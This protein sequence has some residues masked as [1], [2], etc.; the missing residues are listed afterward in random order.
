MAG[1]RKYTRIPPE[2]TG[3]RL[4][5]KSHT[6]IFYDQK[7]K[8]IALDA[9]LTLI[10]SGLVG[11]VVYVREDTTDTGMIAV[12]WNNSSEDSDTIVPVVGEKIQLDNGVVAEVASVAATEPYDT[13]A[14]VSTT[15]SYDNHYQGQMVSAQGEAY[16]R[17]GEGPARVNAAGKLEIDPSTIIAEYPFVYTRLAN[18][19]SAIATGAGTATHDDTTGALVLSTTTSAADKITYRSNLWHHYTPGVPVIS[20]LTVDFG[21]TGKANHIRRWGMFDDNDG[22]FFEL[23]ATTFG[24]V[25]RTSTSG[26]VQETNIPRS[27]WNRDRLDGSGSRATNPSGIDIDFSKLNVFWM[28]YTWHGAGIVRFGIFAKGQRIVCHVESFANNNA[29][30]YMRRASLPI[31]WELENTG[32]TASVNELRCWSASVASGAQYDP[33]WAAKTFVYQTN[34]PQTLSGLTETPIVGLRSKGT[35]QGIENHTVAALTRLNAWAYDTTTGAEGI[36]KIRLYINATINGEF[37]SRDDESAVEINDTA[38]T[39]SNGMLLAEYYL[40]SD[41]EWRFDDIIQLPYRTIIQNADGTIPEFVFTA[42]QQFGD[43]D[44]AFELQPRWKEVIG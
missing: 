33:Q 11:R 40:R 25:R 15:V 4:R 6:N 38:T 39:V 5:V 35:F 31:T 32:I 3:D 17:F 26:T 28:D 10:T 30:A 7:I 29:V 41:H 34:G 20:E 22:L 14:N 16:V 21:D 44:L 19:F 37:T 12:N 9:T 43:N 2:S 42:Q 23:T 1:N 27:D 18:E 13:Y 24:F 36:V 8:E